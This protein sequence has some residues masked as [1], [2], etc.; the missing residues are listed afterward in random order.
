[1]K[2]KEAILRWGS[3][4]EKAEIIYCALENLF[5]NSSYGIPYE[6]KGSISS[7]IM[8]SG[9]DD[10]VYLIKGMVA[11]TMSFTISPHLPYAANGALLDMLLSNNEPES[12]PQIQAWLAKSPGRDATAL[13]SGSVCSRAS[14]KIRS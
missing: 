4:E 5:S 14:N 12:V 2:H 3:P 11:G 6:A 9:S 8:A 7:S 13:Y 10:C 1:M